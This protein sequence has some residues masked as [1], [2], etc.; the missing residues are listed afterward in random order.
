MTQRSK[1]RFNPFPIVKRTFINLPFCVVFTTQPLGW[2]DLNRTGLR[3]GSDRL[4]PESGRLY[5]QHGYIMAS[6]TVV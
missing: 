4:R 6:I 3:Q 2:N 1:E 5:V